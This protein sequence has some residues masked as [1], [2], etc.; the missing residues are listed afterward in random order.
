MLGLHYFHHTKNEV[1][2]KKFLQY[3]MRPNPQETTALVTFTEEILNGKLYFCAMYY[4]KTFIRK[5]YTGQVFQQ[6]LK[7]KTGWF[8]IQLL[9]FTT[10]LPLP[11]C[12]QKLAS[13]V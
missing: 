3:K 11:L 4:M 6:L 13:L 10:L 12:F 2:I 1:F 5:E 9:T 7:Y 8:S